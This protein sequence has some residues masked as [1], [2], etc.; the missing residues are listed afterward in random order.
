[1]PKVPKLEKKVPSTAGP[2][3]IVI[4]EKFFRGKNFTFAGFPEVIDVQAHVRV[5]FFHIFQI[6]I[7]LNGPFSRPTIIGK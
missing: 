7:L 5:I 2:V 6:R 4:G 3:V 1:M